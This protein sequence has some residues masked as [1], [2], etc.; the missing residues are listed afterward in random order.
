MRV[1]RQHVE[2]RDDS[3][4]S[5]ENRET[6][7][8]LGRIFAVRRIR[9]PIINCVLNDLCSWN[10]SPL[11]CICRGHLLKQVT[12]MPWPSMLIIIKCRVHKG[13]CW[14]TIA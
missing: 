13:K 9:R 3:I 5:E 6:E 4:F 11:L 1:D 14:A 8:L 2:S 12:L 10:P 7:V